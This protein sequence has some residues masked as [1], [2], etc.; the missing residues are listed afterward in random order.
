MHLAGKAQAIAKR[1]GLNPDDFWLHKFRVTPMQRLTAEKYRA[2]L[3]ALYIGA[4]FRSLVAPADEEGY[5]NELLA[6]YDDAIER[7]EH[8]TTEQQLQGALVTAKLRGLLSY[9]SK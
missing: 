8:I 4:G 5:W 7:A 9:C 6:A 2:E 3:E 1:G